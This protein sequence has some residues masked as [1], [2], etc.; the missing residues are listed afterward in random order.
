[1]GVTF[2][3]RF[4]VVAEGSLF[5]MNHVELNMMN[6]ITLLSAVLLFGSLSL[7]AQKS[8]KTEISETKDKTTGILLHI[9]AGGQLPGGDLADRFGINGA[10][11]GGTE[12]ITSKNFFVGLEGAFLFGNEVK[13]DPLSI[14][15][16][17]SGDIIGNDRSPAELRLQ[18]RG[19]YAGVTLG[20]LFAFGVAREGLRL[21][22]G[23]GWAQHKI[24]VLDD[25]HTVVQLR[26]DY[27]KGY[28]R[29]SGGPALQQFIGWQHIGYGRDVSW[30]AGFEFNQ[31]FTST[32]RDW[33]FSSM[34]KLEGRRTDLRFGIR[35]SWTLPFFTGNAEEIY[36]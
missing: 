9:S 13:E 11:G 24:R 15:R 2:A 31:A 27:K 28:D 18:Q 22:L 16:M 25:T 34:K 19:V 7:R 14:L 30:M 35:I 36:Y 20:K 8:D 6:K 23:G 4:G 1:M 32:L 26:G 5:R 3:Q 12:F 21:S 33:D 29:L 17:P 10:L